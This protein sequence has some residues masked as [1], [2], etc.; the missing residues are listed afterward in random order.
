MC[1][2]VLR[3]I[4]FMGYRISWA[5]MANEKTAKFETR[6]L[7]LFMGIPYRTFFTRK[8]RCAQLLLPLLPAQ[9]QV[10]KFSSPCEN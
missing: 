4:Q 10:P 9:P 7:S 2:D 1:M 5:T 6:P 8:G 3:N